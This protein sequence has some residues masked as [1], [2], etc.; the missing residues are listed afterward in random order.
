MKAPG[1]RLL[2]VLLSS[3]GCAHTASPIQIQ[4]QPDDILH[5][6]CQTPLGDCL[7]A[8]ENACNHQRYVVLRAFDDHNLKGDTTL[9]DDFRSSEAYVRCGNAAGWG[10]E[11]QALRANPLDATP[12][13]AAPAAPARAC[14][15]GA[16][17][18]CVGP[19]GCA[20]GQSCA[21]DGASFGPC[22]CGASRPR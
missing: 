15:P 5:L 17:Q 13:S 9:P 7:I 1:R 2:A 11:N 21:P 14:V 3:L 6:R 8:A 4:R 20:G 19:G 22:D 18:A 12:P 16:T 10:P